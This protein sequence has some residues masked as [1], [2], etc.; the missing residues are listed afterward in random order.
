ML[1][2]DEQKDV[3]IIG[4]GLAGLSAAIEAGEAGASVLVLE[5][6][7]VTGGN[8]RI[9]DGGVAAPKN[10]LQKKQGIE[11]SPELFYEDM[12]RAGLGLNHPHLLKILA[13]RATE[14]IRWTRDTLGVKYLDRLDRFG[15]HSVAR[16]L[17]TL[18]HSGADFIRMQCRKLEQQGVEIRTRCLLTRLYQ[19]RNGVVRGVQIRSGYKFPEDNSGIARNIHAK[20][21]VILATGGFGNDIQFR[22]NQNPGLDES[23][24]STNHQG[25]TADGLIAA[26]EIGAVPVHLSWIQLGPWGCAD[27]KGYGRGASFAS[28]SVYPCGILIDPATGRRIVNEWADR[29]TRSDA[30][31]KTGH[32]CLGIV[33]ANGVNNAAESLE[34]SLKRGYVKA[35]P[36]L[37]DLASAYGIADGQV[38][39]TVERYNRT[40]TEDGQDPFGKPL[41]HGAKPL[42][43]PPFYA[44]RLW[45]KVHYTPGGVGINSKA[46]VIDLQGH[47]IPHLFAAGEVCGGIHGASRLG[48]CALTECIVFGRIAGQQA[49]ANR[50]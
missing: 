37:G 6:M 50:Y 40:I 24:D 49:A 18:N 48:S 4:S 28:Y 26:L 31:F 16:C 13:E 45:P 11:D 30:I 41:A 1:N 10:Y 46:Q 22:M 12:L 35:F 27:E 44:I 15:G 33:D 14:A 29:R 34:H 9:S 39:G 17:T 5:K 23:V 8:T 43:H 7:K 32:V 38:Q 36:T 21:A 2:W 25:A 3:I 47:P 19:D 42:V 20:R